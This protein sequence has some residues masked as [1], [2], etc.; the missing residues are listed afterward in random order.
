MERILNYKSDIF[1]SKD[2]NVASIITINSDI[3]YIKCN[4]KLTCHIYFFFKKKEVKRSCRLVSLHQN[5]SNGKIIQV[6][7]SK[8]EF[9]YVFN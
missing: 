9:I 7:D 2:I 6:V 4:H 8:E 3:L 1:Y 5:S